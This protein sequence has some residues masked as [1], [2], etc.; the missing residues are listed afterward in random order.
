[1]PGVH[2]RLKG[3]HIPSRTWARDVTLHVGD[4]T[5]ERRKGQR[6]GNIMPSWVNL[7]EQDP[8][9]LPPGVRVWAQDL[10]V[11]KGPEI[12]DV[13]APLPKAQL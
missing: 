13:S 3:I 8:G 4:K 7:L 2:C 1:M 12:E 11:P 9:A 6:I 5:I 10:D